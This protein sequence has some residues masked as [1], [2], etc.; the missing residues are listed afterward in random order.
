MRS[1]LA[2][3]K[4]SNALFHYICRSQG[5]WTF[6]WG[7]ARPRERR[8]SLANCTSFTSK[9]RVCT[10]VRLYSVWVGAIDGDKSVIYFFLSS[11]SIGLLRGTHVH[12]K[13]LSEPTLAAKSLGPLPLYNSRTPAQTWRVGDVLDV[14]YSVGHKL[15]Y[16]HC[17]WRYIWWLPCQVCTRMYTIYIYTIYK[18]I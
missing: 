11:I 9:V 2:R 8:L 18:H 17:T 1:S 13:V 3:S 14:S 6:L 12:T 4:S 7:S 5:S 15:I 16:Q 10:Y